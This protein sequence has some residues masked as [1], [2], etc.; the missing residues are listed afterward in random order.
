V[1]LYALL[2]GNLPFNHPDIRVLL[3]QVRSGVYEMPPYLHRDMKSLIT[4][5]LEVDPEKR[6]TLAQ[7]RRDR[8]F[9]SNKVT[10][11]SSPGL[12]RVTAEQMSALP[13]APS[14]ELVRTI[15]AL[16]IG[17]TKKHVVALL[18]ISEAL[19]RSEQATPGS[20]D[21]TGELSDDAESSDSG[22][23]SL[24][25]TSKRYRKIHDAVLAQRYYVLIQSRQ[26]EEED[27][28]KRVNEYHARGRRSSMPEAPKFRASEG[29]A[30]P[31]K[32]KKSISDRGG[33]SMSE[34][35]R[36]A[37]RNKVK[38]G[39]GSAA[40]TSSAGAALSSRNRSGSMVQARPK[41]L[42]EV[43]A[44]RSPQMR[45]RSGSLSGGGA[46][47]LTGGPLPGTLAKLLRPQ[48]QQEPPAVA[49][50]LA[51]LRRPQSQQETASV[52]SS[53]TSSEGGGSGMVR[54]PS[55]S[56]RDS[57]STLS[58]K[59]FDA[60]TSLPSLD[61]GD[62]PRASFFSPFLDA[63]PM[64]SRRS[65]QSPGSSFSSLPESPL[66]PNSA[67]G[68]PKSPG[69]RRNELARKRSRSAMDRRRP[70]SGRVSPRDV[71]E[72][73]HLSFKI[74]H[75]RDESLSKLREVFDDMQIQFSESVQR[76]RGEHYVIEAEIHGERG[77]EA[78]KFLLKLREAPER[79]MATTPHIRPR[80][81]SGNALD[82]STM[83]AF[84]FVSGD[85]AEFH[86]LCLELPDSRQLQS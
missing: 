31:P 27:V 3:Q 80:S 36:E 84:E 22:R 33:S 26:T 20:G 8:F 48:A 76:G 44:P 14:E 35:A 73:E 85:K 7:I 15:H 29:S 37:L 4:S 18:K 19:E 61:S 11:P 62:E 67:E 69:A 83:L 47:P 74:P 16:G 55:G 86:A 40:E 56:S 65:T 23:S 41:K 45:R 12:D 10:I 34:L 6:I 2:T 60:S 24:S 68:G 50:K 71:A 63:S 46:A 1:I 70:V 54:S 39:V 64:S 66:R 5:M 82:A 72:D 28:D 49:S 53:T 17:R 43:V 42:T 13:A 59:D 30:A 38:A 78:T 21:E 58:V 81:N 75:G 77:S 51:K 52:G 32:A 9:C 25:R 57:N 79:N